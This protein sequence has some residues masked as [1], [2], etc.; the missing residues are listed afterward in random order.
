MIIATF[1]LMP[2]LFRAMLMLLRALMPPYADTII[3]VNVTIIMNV[4][5]PLPLP[6]YAI[7]A[8]PADIFTRFAFFF[9]AID[10]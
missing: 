5:T 4:V 1:S 9:F 3:N 7:F 6:L 8:S 10:D 2:L